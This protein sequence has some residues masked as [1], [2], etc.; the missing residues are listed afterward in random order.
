MSYAAFL[1][2]DILRT[3]YL[4]MK[5][6]ITGLLFL[7]LILISF[8]GRSQQASLFNCSYSDNSSKIKCNL[9]EASTSFEDYTLIKQVKKILIEVGL[10]QNFVLKKCTNL[11]NAVAFTSSD[12]TRYIVVDQSWLGNFGN[13]D[14]LKLS[15]LAHEIGHH[16][17][18]HTLKNPLTLEQSRSD[19]LE[20]DKFSG[21]ILK[22]LGATIA[23]AQSAIN[24]LIAGGS[25]DIYSTHPAK[26]KRLKAI[27][28]GFNGNS[29]LTQTY[30]TEKSCEE[31]LSLGNDYMILSLTDKAIQSYSKA[32]EL[33]SNCV[34]AL[35]NI[36]KAY[37]DKFNPQMA[38]VYFN[39]CIQ[40]RDDW[41]VRNNIGMS[42]LLLDKVN[43]AIS[44]YN[45]IITANISNEA[46]AYAYFNR[47]QAYAKVN[48]WKNACSDWYYSAY[49]GHPQ[50]KSKLSQWCR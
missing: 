50:G 39:K 26:S 46:N 22:Q 30:S 4:N 40:L 31:Y 38:L 49:Y 8:I 15:I 12:G 5:N 11:S 41:V 37:N 2:K 10:P 25:E 48:Y 45:N 13:S 24:S 21:H 6:K 18:G 20:A 44:I 9:L 29:N 23:D 42:V 33:N 16:L 28:D 34:E 1:D 17:A 47:A 35:N 7:K 14:W 3:N 32:L 43:D 36:G 27:Q 19:E